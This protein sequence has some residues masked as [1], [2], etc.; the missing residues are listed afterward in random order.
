[1]S[2]REIIGHGK[3]I[4]ILQRIVSSGR[5]AHAYLFLGPEGT[6]RKKSAEAFIAA[7]FCGRDDACGECPSCR[8][9]AAGNHPDLHLVQPDGQ[10]IKIDQIRALQRELAF[11]PYE[12][13]RKACIIDGA[14]RL[15]Q[16]S[17][18]AL[19]KTLEEPPGNAL[20]IL[21]ATTTD[22]VLPTIR[23]RCQ[24]LLFS[25]IP[26]EEIEAFLCRQG[27]DAETAQVAAS[28]ADGSIARALALCSDDVMAD[29]SAIITA[30]CGLNRQEVLPLFTLGEMF[31]K[32]REKASQAVELLTSFWRDL[33]LLRS[34]AE[35]VVNRDLLPLLHREAAKR[36][37]TVIIDNL[38]QLGRTRSAIL[39]NANVR[40]ALDVLSMRLAV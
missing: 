15:N 24:Q 18:N 4:G 14:D 26:T 39:R 3:S 23:S 1:M 13:P 28:L 7:V 17:G 31:D 16:S 37:E 34:G 36:S 5:I 6:G 21:L 33:L 38:E 22:N 12:A 10:F 11:R 30:A 29:R 35:Q 2:F 20:L 9:F 27:T 40:L 32:E 19:L 8:K 25:G